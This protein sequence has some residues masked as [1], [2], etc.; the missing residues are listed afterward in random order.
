VAIREI[1]LDTNSYSA[2]K[3]NVA[4]AVEVI[5]Q[6]SVIGISTVVLGELLSGFAAGSRESANR[7]ELDKF[8]SSARVKVLA[9]D[10]GTAEHYAA[11]YRDLRTKGRPIPTNDIWIAATALQH[12]LAVFTYDIHFQAVDGLVSGVR[13]SDFLT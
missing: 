3:R 11:V 13:L 2:F 9:V 1:L 7:G 5:Q 6:A 8:L 4:D 12:G 10:R